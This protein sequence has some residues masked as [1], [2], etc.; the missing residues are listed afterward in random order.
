MAGAKKEDDARP[1]RFADLD[2]KD[3]VEEAKTAAPVVGMASQLNRLV[4]KLTVRPDGISPSVILV[5]P[6]GSGKTTLVRRLAMEVLRA[7]R[8]ERA[9]LPLRELF[10]LELGVLLAGTSYRGQLE[11][12]YRALIDACKEDGRYLFID[13]IHAMDHMGR[14]E[15]GLPWLQMIKLDMQSGRLRLIGATTPLEY[16]LHLSKDP[17]AEQRFF[18]FDVEPFTSEDTIAILEQSV[19]RFA[20]IRVTCE[21]GAIEDA[22]ALTHPDVAQPGLGKKTLVD[23]AGDKLAQVSTPASTSSVVIT[24]SDI[25]GYAARHGLH[26]PVGVSLPRVV[27]AAAAS[28]VDCVNVVEGVAEVVAAEWTQWRAEQEAANAGAGHSIQARDA[29]TRA[30]ARIQSMLQERLGEPPESAGSGYGC[31]AAYIAPKADELTVHF[32]YCLLKKILGELHDLRFM[33]G[34]GGDEVR[35]KTDFVR[36]V[37]TGLFYSDTTARERNTLEW[38]GIKV[39]DIAAEVFRARQA[40]G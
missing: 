16:S 12:R 23:I 35:R 26:G 8:G 29:G 18:R 30:V 22:A 27:R 38:N 2:P 6:S 21:P 10:Q 17:A 9:A 14:N 20:G 3:M 34:G 1:V 15:G 5:A 31:L 28:F 4:A 24:R 36:A 25:S 13:E 7:R 19:R 40:A 39:A 11:Q 37:S 32:G 33:G